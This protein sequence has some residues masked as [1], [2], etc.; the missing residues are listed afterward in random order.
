M[1]N[2]LFIEQ[3]L[4]AAMNILV[5][6]QNQR[7]NQRHTPN[8]SGKL[9]EVYDATFANEPGFRPYGQYISCYCLESFKPDTTTNLVVNS[10]VPQWY[11]EASALEKINNWIQNLNSE[12]MV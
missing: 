2:L 7:H 3:D 10:K 12:T 8:C 9:L 6:D 1:E 11:L 4:G 5:V